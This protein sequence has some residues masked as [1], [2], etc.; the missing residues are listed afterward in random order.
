MHGRSS[1]VGRAWR[2]RR[3]VLCSV[4]GATILLLVAGVVLPVMFASH[5]APK[6]STADAIASLPVPTGKPKAAGAS[7]KSAEELSSSGV[8]APRGRLAPLQP[9][10]PHALTV[11]SGTGITKGS[12]VTSRSTFATVYANPDGTR[13]AKLSVTPQRTKNSDGAWVR[14]NSTVSRADSGGFVVKDNPLQPQFAP[15]TGQ[16]QDVSVKTLAGNSVSFSL[17]GATSVKA[18]RPSKV[19][20]ASSGDPAAKASTGV[21]YPGA[22]PGGDVTYQVSPGM[23]KEAVVLKSR[24]EHGVTFSWTITAPGMTLVPGRAGSVEYRDGKGRTVL[25]MP[26]PLMSDSSGV[27]GVSGNAVTTVP[28]SLK[29]LGGGKWRVTLTPDASWLNDS[30]RAYPVAV[31]PSTMQINPGQTIGYESSNG[32]N[33]LATTPYANIGNSLANGPTVWRTVAYYP[34]ESL[35]GKQILRADLAE[36]YAGNGTLNAETVGSSNAAVWGFNCG[37]QNISYASFGSGSGGSADLDVTAAIKR[38]VDASL[39]G[40]PLCLGGDETLTAYTYKQLNTQLF[41]Q[42]E[43]KP[44]VAAT[45]S[46][47]PDPNPGFPAQTTSPINGATTSLAP[48]LQATSTQDSGNTQAV[49][50]SFSV[51]ASSNMANPLWSTGWTSSSLVNLPQARLAAG[52]TY[53]WQIQVQDMYGTTASSPTYSFK[54]TTLPTYGAASAYAPA[55]NS[56]VATTTPTL[57]A[58]QATSTNGHTLK[59]LLRITTGNDGISGQIAQTGVCGVAG[60]ACTINPDGTVSWAVPA[61]L[62]RD[63][64]AYTWTLVVNDGYGDYVQ[65]GSTTT[66][67]N[68]LAVNMRVTNSGPA[69]VTS[70][71]PV[72][73]NTANGNVSASF[74]SPTVNTVGGAMG[75]NFVYNSQLASNRGLT[76]TYWNLPTT[77]TYPPAQSAPTGATTA[78]VRTDNNVSFNWETDAPAPGVSATNYQVQWTGYIAPPSGTYAFGFMSDDGA[79]LQL[80][81]QSVITDHWGLRHDTAPAME[82]AASQTLTVT[83]SSWSL[84]GQ[85]GTLPLPITV[86]FYQHAGT[87][88]ISFQVEQKS[89]SSWV[90]QQVVPASWLTRSPELLPSGWGS[91]GPN[92]G[93]ATQF[94]KAVSQGGSVIVT[95]SAGGQHTFTKTGTGGYTPPAGESDVLT[96]DQAGRVTLTDTAGTVYL[97]NATGK[98]TSVTPAVDAGSKPATPVPTYNAQGQLAS[99]SDPLSNTGTGTT[100]TYQRSLQFSYLT[101]TTIAQSTMSGANRATG[102]CA[103]P[104]GSGFPTAITATAG[105]VNSDSG[106]LCQILYPD[107]TTSQLY[108]D[109]NGQLAEVVDPGNE[110]TYFGY[111]VDAGGNYLLSAIRSP[112]ANDWLAADISRNVN[113]PVSTSIVYDS[114]DRATGVTL[115]APDGVSAAA[116][117]VKTFTYAT[118]ATATTPGTT[119]VDV[120]GLTPPTTSPANGHGETVTFSPTLQKLTDTSASGLTSQTVWNSH[121]NPLAAIDPQGHESSTVYDTQDRATDSYGPAP[122]ACYGAT[123]GAPF[124]PLTTD[125]DGAQDGPIPVASCAQMNGTAIAHTAATYDGGMHGLNAT[126]YNNTLVSGAP[127]AYSLSIPGSSLTSPENGGALKHDW[128]SGTA[129]SPITGLTGTVVGGTGGTNWTAQFTGLLTFPATGT[130][131]LYTYAD[132]GTQLWINDTL[133]IDQWGSHAAAYSSGY[134]IKATAGQVV[135]IRLAYLQLGVSAHLE[136]DWT[137]PGTGGAATPLPTTAANNVAIPGTALSPAYNLVTATKTDDSAPAGISGVSNANTPGASTSTSY[138]NPWFGTVASTSVDPTGLNLTATSTTEAPGTGYLRQVTA[139]KPAGPSTTTSTAYYGSTGN[140]TVGYGTALGI[141]SPVCGIPLTTPQDGLAESIAEPASAAGLPIITRFVHDVLGRV[142]GTLLP[143]DSDWSCTY[144][145]ARGR[146][147][148]QTDSPLGTRNVD[149]GYVGD[150]LNGTQSGDPLTSWVRDSS[151]QGT[152]TGGIVYSTIDL[153]GS[154]VKYID[155]WGATTTTVLNRALQTL[156]STTALPDQSTHT[157]SYTYNSDGQTQSVEED[158]ATVATVVYES[159]TMVSVVYPAGAG[160]SGNGSAGAFQYAPTGAPTGLTWTFASGNAVADVHAMS[161]QGRIVLDRLTDGQTNYESTY[162]YD[163]AGRLT[164]ARIPFNVQSYDYANAG[165]CGADA[166]SGANG[167]RT[168]FTDTTTAPGATSSSLPLAVTYCYDNADRLTSDTIVNAPVGADALAS[169]NLGSNGT[170]PNLTYDQHGNI[171]RLGPQ[172][173]TYDDANR[174]TSTTL[175]DGSG[176]SYGRDAENRVVQVVQRDVQGTSTEWHYVY[177]GVSDTPAFILTHAGTVQTQSI[178]LIGGATLQR[179]TAGQVWSYPNLSGH[180]TVTADQMGQRSGGVSL[181]DPFGN[182]IDLATGLIGTSAADA[183]APQNGDGGASAFGYEGRYGK[184]SLN[185]GEVASIEMGARQYVPFLG[186]FLSVDPQD[187]G[188][189][190]DY[191]YPNDPINNSD[192]SG[193]RSITP[194]GCGAKCAPSKSSSE[195]TQ[196]FLEVNAASVIGLLGSAPD[197][198]V[199]SDLNALSDSMKA[200]AEKLTVE[201]AAKAAIHGNSK[202]STKTASLYRL[203]TEDGEY[204]K[205]GISQNPAKRYSQ[206]AMQGRTL[207]VLT[208]GTRAE[209]LAIERAIVEIDGGPL[210]REPWSS[211]RKRAF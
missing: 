168:S 173:I 105:T 152:S 30:A 184:P 133:V 205:T 116:A 9:A 118:S 140:P 35:F 185:L 197:D 146:V 52:T 64:V 18:S 211:W 135:R 165:A 68:R 155:S 17:D 8:Q 81:G 69:P 196:A 100:P 102:S 97:F 79:G 190:N 92:L 151:I 19:D 143:G 157:E 201:A 122:A 34:Y 126:W 194:F 159:G 39:N 148:Q 109:A 186:R 154:L 23:V 149:Y 90:N 167:N 136:L 16:G 169:A 141:S 75:V 48:F 104:S 26:T 150:G 47:V 99:I 179:S 45:Q 164:G 32:S 44:T 171:T 191:N 67:V 91:S 137:T 198:P 192:P 63:G 200:E 98:V 53:Y 51:S 107:G 15:A 195:V 161:Q 106:M 177:T 1:W 59:Y 56:V 12:K 134:Q 145:D 187:G 108:Y 21:S 27:A 131:T 74:S 80:A 142:A 3:G 36:W 130:Y 50:Y 204:L 55:D 129:V 33:L 29:K 89:G 25:L 210:N 153:D 180:D 13:T 95:D 40:G 112:L 76:G 170:T 66:N 6:R 117:P 199:A 174:H 132:D 119:Y 138:S 86:N 22:V 24:P 42:Y 183:S 54:T 96:T 181:F 139:T 58:P 85:S 202:S 103:P 208:T 28:V 163:G 172:T 87:S 176:I 77:A 61:G 120:A 166:H 38:N 178:E 10:A 43:N 37:G 31:D 209:M 124:G 206:K 84:N 114:S 57:M 83:G 71:G 14:V 11:V 72:T 2:Q 144:Y 189:A 60:S 78:L 147:R 41:I 158:G 4:A 121:D 20:V 62:L 125:A 162:T 207:Q 113:G 82:T 123:A 175:P 93:D 160:N 70:A 46:S 65:S 110:T 128:G 115:P 193:A 101:N 7:V 94:V 5:D 73:V 111:Q 188:N 88:A 203:E 156:S 182:P 49:N 127:A